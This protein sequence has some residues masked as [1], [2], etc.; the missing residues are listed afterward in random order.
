MSNN[1]VIALRLPDVKPTDLSVSE[2][3][4]LLKHLSSLLKNAEAK[5]K[6]IQNGSSYFGNTI[7][8]AHLA[9]IKKSI[10]LSEGGELDRYIGKHHT[11]GD[12]AIGFHDADADPKTMT[13][14]RAIS[15]IDKPNKFK[16][17]DTLR[18]TVKKL[19]EGKDNTDHVGI[20]FLNGTTLSAKATE[21]VASAL[22]DYFRTDTII[23]FTGEATYS[24]SSNF[25]LT[26]EDFKIISFEALAI[27]SLN[28]WIDDFVGFGH[29]GWQDLNNPLETLKKE[30]LS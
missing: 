23:E 4:E 18:G 14:I 30:R 24:H 15:P 28:Q 25:E 7:N 20:A 27:D 26:L 17:T 29:S 1:I 22:K 13:I 5:F 8:A 2:V 6:Y 12:A 3:S 21:S 11:W 9:D 16:Q 19:I 10:L